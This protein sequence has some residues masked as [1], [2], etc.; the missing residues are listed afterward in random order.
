[1]SLIS[2]TEIEHHVEFKEQKHWYFVRDL[3][4]DNYMAISG[5][6]ANQ[7]YHEYMKHNSHKL[8]SI[9]N[10]LLEHPDEVTELQEL[11]ADSAY[12]AKN[13]EDYM[14][15]MSRLAEA[16]EYFH[17]DKRIPKGDLRNLFLNKSIDLEQNYVENYLEIKAFL[18]ENFSKLEFVL[19]KVT[20][21]NPKLIDRNKFHKLLEQFEDIDDKIRSKEK[22]D[23]SR[24]ELLLL[25][26]LS[27][28]VS[29]IENAKALA[30]YYS[31]AEEKN[32]KLY[33]L[34]LKLGEYE[35]SVLETL[36][37]YAFKVGV[38]T[39]CCQ[40]IGGVGEAAAVD[41]FI[42]PLASVLVLKRNGRILAQSYFHYVPE[43]NG[44][45]LDNIEVNEENLKKNYIDINGVGN[46]S[47]P[48]SK[49]YIKFAQ[50]VK[51]KYPDIK[52]INVGLGN[53]WVDTELFEMKSSDDDPR[54]FAV[55]DP[56]SDY[57]EN[58]FIDL[59]Q[60]KTAEKQSYKLIKL[61]KIAY[62][63]SKRLK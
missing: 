22:I 57:Y 25:I 40:R 54:Y 48:L 42:N 47:T 14:K 34:N 4:F 23:L 56:Y 9:A 3:L 21:Q 8:P 31:Q 51:S 36:D 7:F 46:K 39:D 45:I 63:L 15:Y 33:R 38:D 11:A 41:S 62:K 29:K 52:Y 19:N 2:L 37:P 30:K 17:N 1:M 5:K 27:T 16:A 12:K 18:A 43:E 53:S 24:K 59:L 6:N 55:D 26:E 35:F 13:S 28:E 61:L 20:S 58:S 50:A 32:E 10:D 60:P 49:I 44:Y